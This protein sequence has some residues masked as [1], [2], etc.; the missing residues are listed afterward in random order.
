M[1]YD[2]DFE[3]KYK[4]RVSGT[5]LIDIPM[6]YEDLRYQTKKDPILRKMIIFMEI[7]NI[8]SCPSSKKIEVTKQGIFQFGPEETFLFKRNHIDFQGPFQKFILLI[9]VDSYWKFPFVVKMSGFARTHILSALK[10]IFA[11]EEQP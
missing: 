1:G 2:K 6:N 9:I 7:K 4:D 3:E 11:L 10:S 8:S 5:S